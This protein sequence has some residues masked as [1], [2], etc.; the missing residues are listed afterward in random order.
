M[1][2]DLILVI[3]LLVFL[4]LIWTTYFYIIFFSNKENMENDKDNN[5]NENGFIIQNNKIPEDFNY[6]NLCYKDG[7]INCEE[8]NEEECQHCPLCVK[9]YK[10]VGSQVEF[11]KCLNSFSKEFN[12]KDLNIDTENENY[13]GKHKNS[14]DNSLTCTIDK[15]QCV[16][17]DCSNAILNANSKLCTYKYEHTNDGN[18][19]MCEKKNDHEWINE[20]KNKDNKNCYKKTDIRLNCKFCSELNIAECNYCKACYWDTENNKCNF[21]PISNKDNKISCFN[22]KC[23]NIKTPSDCNR[24]L[25]CKYEYTYD[26]NGNPKYNDYGQHEGNCKNINS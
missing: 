9:K 23:D 21:I 26:K 8:K 15:K 14:C 25:N 5:E 18:R 3:L 2:Q 16:Q 4:V 10:L 19:G 7:K 1:N 11:D 22:N 24:C 12:C 6:K 20:A 17:T 13:N